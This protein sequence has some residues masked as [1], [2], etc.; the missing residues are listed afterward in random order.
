MR[1][2]GISVFFS[3][4]LILLF[5]ARIHA[6]SSSFQQAIY[7]L[8]ECNDG[9][10]NDNNGLIDFASDTGCTSFTDTNE[11]VTPQTTINPQAPLTNA[12]API[13]PGFAAEALASAEQEFLWSP[14]GRVLGIENSDQ[15]RDYILFTVIIIFTT[16]CIGALSLMLII[17]FYKKSNHAK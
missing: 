2:L 5:S 16:A 7:P 11:G 10:D 6:T 4:S 3:F 14:I 1:I 13:L 9:I 17:R 8:T 15:S 12:I